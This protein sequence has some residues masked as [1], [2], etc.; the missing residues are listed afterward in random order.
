MVDIRICFVGDSFVNG[1]GDEEFLGWTGRVCQAATKAGHSITAY[2]LGIR[3]DTSADIAARWEV[4]CDRRLPPDCDSRVVF[5]FGANDTTVEERQRRL[6]SHASERYAEEI[7]RAASRRFKTLF[8][9]PPPVA[10]TE[11]NERIVEVGALFREVSSRCGVCYLSV[12][13]PLRE[14]P[15]WMSA[16]R[17]GDGA[18]PNSRGYA[19]MA[20]LILRWPAW[21][22]H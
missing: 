5:S 21:W 11:H 1:T 6:T 2:N 9:G 4:E 3:R 7:L 20:E 12:I 13:E 15:G 10:D 16:V 19:Q 8:I 18:H 17:S 22:F 14:C